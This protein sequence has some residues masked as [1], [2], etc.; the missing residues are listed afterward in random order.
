M[1]MIETVNDQRRNI[2]QVEHTRH[3]SVLN[4]MVNLLAGLIS[5]T[6]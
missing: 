3:R 6:Q 5:Y 2:T 4:F 1:T